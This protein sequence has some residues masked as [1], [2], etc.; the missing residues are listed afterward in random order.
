MAGPLELPNS[1]RT[2]APMAP[3]GPG[4][5]IM[6]QSSGSGPLGHN[7]IDAAIEVEISRGTPAAFAGQHNA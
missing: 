5:A 7:Q 3:T 4:P 1:A 6:Q 2:T